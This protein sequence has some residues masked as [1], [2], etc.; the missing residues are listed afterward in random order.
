MSLTEGIPSPEIFRK[1]S[2]ISMVAA[3]LERRVWLRAGER[4]CFA[5][6]Y[7]I[8]V[9]HPGVGKQIIETGHDLLNAINEPG[10]SKAPAFHLG[11][12][13]CTKASLIDELNS[14]SCTH[15]VQSGTVSYHSLTFMSE[16]FSVL[17]PNYDLEFIGKLNYIFDNKP[18]YSETRRHGPVRR[19]SIDFPQ[20][21]ILGG[22]QPAYFQ[23]TFPEEA[24]TTGLSRRIIM[25]YANEAPLR[26][27][28][29][30]PAIP[31]N[32]YTSVLIRLAHLS[33]LWGEITWGT[34]CREF[35]DEWH[36][37]GE[38][39]KPTH[40]RL[41]HY[42]RSRYL[43]VMKLAIV[44][45]ISRSGTFAMELCDLQRA[46]EWLFEA[47]A[48]MPDVFRA[49]AGKSDREIL[50]RLHQFAYGLY[51][52]QGRK[53]PITTNQLWTFLTHQVPSG[54]IPAIM[55]SAAR[56]GY[57]GLMPGTN[58]MWI[59]RPQMQHGVE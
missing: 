20:L 48:L 57:M 45:T 15:I 13:S 34:G 35:I 14:A 26:S 44:A 10:N 6:L 7:T 40:S 9:A 5:N 4:Q 54:H 12:N 11:S 46:F 42:N 28:F 27:L 56:L 51:V 43:F 30:I 1:W 41:T 55:H 16:E 58:D 21:N 19:V 22:A 18:R 3:G 25:V 29:Y 39:P 24:W 47:E 32:S 31:A 49:M 23:S 8:L 50:E 53:T 17:L 37:G 36:L 52:K 2:A 33:E 59:P 38:E